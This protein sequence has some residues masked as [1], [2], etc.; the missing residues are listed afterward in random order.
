ME[1]KNPTA[2]ELRQACSAAWQII[3][4]T[5]ATSH[6]KRFANGWALRAERQYPL[7]A[8]PG[9]AWNPCYYLISPTGKNFGGYETANGFCGYFGNPYGWQWIDDYKANGFKKVTK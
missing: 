9:P 6:E 7:P 1:T 2:K 5:D 4:K 8:R 3:S